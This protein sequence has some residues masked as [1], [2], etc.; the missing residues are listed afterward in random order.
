M[1]AVI[2]PFS[3]TGNQSRTH[4]KETLED[5]VEYAKINYNLKAIPQNP[6][7]VLPAEKPAKSESDEGRSIAV[8]SFS[9][10]FPSSFQYIVSEWA[11]K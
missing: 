5:R 9:G 1:Y 10:P 6:I 7:P 4:V 2:G 3:S 11:C 8:A